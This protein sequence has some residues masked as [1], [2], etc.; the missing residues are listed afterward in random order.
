MF[1]LLV[2]FYIFECIYSSGQETE[3]KDWKTEYYIVEQ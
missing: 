1:W 3:F 2:N